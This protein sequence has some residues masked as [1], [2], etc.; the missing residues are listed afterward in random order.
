M[1]GALVDKEGLNLTQIRLVEELPLDKAIKIGT[2]PIKVVE[3][4]DPDCPYCRKASQF[5]RV[6]TSR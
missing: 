5:L 3:V 2:G 4:T 1:F 6:K